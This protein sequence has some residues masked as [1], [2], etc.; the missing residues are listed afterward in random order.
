MSTLFSQIF[1]FTLVL[2][3]AGLYAVT[4]HAASSGTTQPDDETNGTHASRYGRSYEARQTLEKA[5]REG[6]IERPEQIDRIER[7]ER[8][9]RMERIERPGRVERIERPGR[10]R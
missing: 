7:V 3:I 4:A 1:Q 5:D 8:P 2:L 10:G 6:R 9:E